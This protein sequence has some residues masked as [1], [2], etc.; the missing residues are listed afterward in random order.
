M[1]VIHSQKCNQKSRTNIG[2]ITCNSCNKCYHS[3]CYNF[4]NQPGRFNRDSWVCNKCNKPKK[5]PG[6]TKRIN[7]NHLKYKCIS[8]SNFFHKKC[9]RIST[10][11]SHNWPCNKCLLQELPF[12]LLDD[13]SFS[14]TLKGKI[15]ESESLQLLPSFSVKTL[16]DKLPGQIELNFH[17]DLLGSFSSKYYTPHE[18]TRAKLPKNCLSIFHLNINSLQKH[19]DELN[20]LLGELQHVFDFI[21]I[22][23]TRILKDKGVT[24]NI[25]INGYEFVSTPTE[26]M[27]GGVGIYVKNG[28]DYDIIPSISICE[29]KVAES[30]FIEIRNKKKKKNIIVGT[31]Y[32]IHLLNSILSLMAF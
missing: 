31:I 13:I 19:I 24:T 18:F 16:L 25:K 30:I 15:L 14:L 29:P 9:G 17:D 21:T 11:N 26:S 8:C 10:E 7:F 22:S 6:C 12:Y 32:N 4:K 27:A 3:R 20:E 28:L 2:T 23:E 1:K 5:C